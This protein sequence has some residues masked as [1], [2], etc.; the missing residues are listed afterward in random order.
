MSP[1]VAHSWYSPR[2]PIS[3]W[4]RCGFPSKY[5]SSKHT[6][7]KTSNSEFFKGMRKATQLNPVVYEP[8]YEKLLMGVA[9]GRYVWLDSI[10]NIQMAVRAKDSGV[11]KKVLQHTNN[12]H[13]GEI[14]SLKSTSCRVFTLHPLHGTQFT[15]WCLLR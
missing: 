14:P 13:A 2:L 10:H 9:S 8:D 5:G 4:M 3:S 6:Q 1:M 7:V 11:K 12:L 15:L